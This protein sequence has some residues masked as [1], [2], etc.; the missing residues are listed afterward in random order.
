MFRA[1]GRV[2][3]SQLARLY[4]CRHRR[5]DGNILKW[6][7][8]NCMYIYKSS[9]FCWYGTIFSP[10]RNSVYFSMAILKYL[11]FSMNLSAV[12]TLNFLIC[13]CIFPSIGLDSFHISLSKYFDISISFSSRVTQG[14]CLVEDFIS[15]LYKFLFLAFESTF[16]DCYAFEN[17]GDIF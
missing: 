13:S 15:C 7:S 8:I 9:V 5:R 6:H 16:S 17:V 10:Q 2:S 11:T 12:F 3:K 1:V 14:S 4:I